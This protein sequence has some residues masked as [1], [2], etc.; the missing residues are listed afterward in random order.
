MDNPLDFIDFDE[1]TQH[2]DPSRWTFVGPKP[3]SGVPAHSSVLHQ[4]QQ[5][6]MI[7]IGTNSETR[8][9]F[10]ISVTRMAR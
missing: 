1:V 8:S 7:S 5:N 10:I 3:G 6:I 2:G 9:K 4:A